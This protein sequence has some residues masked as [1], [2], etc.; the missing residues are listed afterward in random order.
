MEVGVGVAV[1]GAGV[2][3][4]TLGVA[5][6]AAHE[7][8]LI[9]LVSSETWPLRASIR[10]WTV[11]PVWRVMLLSAST[12][13]TKLVVVPIVAELPTCQYTL[14]AWAPPVSA[15]ALPL[16]VTSVEPAWN[17]KTAS[18]SPW[19]SSVT[20]PVS[21][22]PLEAEYTP[23]TRVCPPR[24]WLVLSTTGPR[25]AASLYAVVRSSCAWRATAS[26]AWMVPAFTWPG[27]KPVTA[28]PGLTPRSPETTPGPVLVTVVPAST[29]N[30]VAVPRPTGAC[31]AT[32]TPGTPATRANAVAAA[33]TGSAS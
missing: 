1:D 7:G 15:T 33:A 11:A 19:P 18:G 5:E 12:D 14:Q 23:G 17:T 25:P 4:V 8:R 20:V 29:A 27:G 9:V 3:G 21:A 30:D 28:D 13:P 31:A 10:P 2:V 32:A 16:L 26:A 6:G 22:I 24:S